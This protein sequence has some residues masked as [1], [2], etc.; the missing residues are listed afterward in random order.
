MPLGD[1]CRPIPGT[2]DV[3]CVTMHESAR[4]T[5]DRLTGRQAFD[6]VQT[7][8][9]WGEAYIRARM[10]RPLGGLVLLALLWWAQRDSQW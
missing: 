2:D 6:P 3:L 1:E 5:A 8:R 7:A 4:A 9:R 10:C